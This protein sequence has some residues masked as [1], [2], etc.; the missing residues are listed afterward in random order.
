MAIYIIFIVSME[1]LILQHQFNIDTFLFQLQ[2][3]DGIFEGSTELSL[4][5]VIQGAENQ[6]ILSSTRPS[7][8]YTSGK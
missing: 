7:I 4:R 2:R 5:T 6:L 8:L 3:R 1:I